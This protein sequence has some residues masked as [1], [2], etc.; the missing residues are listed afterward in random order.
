MCEVEE[1]A[2]ATAKFERL[3][4]RVTQHRLAARIRKEPPGNLKRKRMHVGRC[5][6]EPGMKRMD[7]RT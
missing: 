3:S 2:R 6:L 7:G 1:H 4:R 5:I